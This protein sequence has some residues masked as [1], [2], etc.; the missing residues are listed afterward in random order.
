MNIEDKWKYKASIKD[1]CLEIALWN[2]ILFGQPEDGYVCGCRTEG[3]MTTLIRML[4]GNIKSAQEY[5]R[6]FNY[7][8][9]GPEGAKAVISIKARTKEQADRHYVKIVNLN[10]VLNLDK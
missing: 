6:S 1:D 2:P 4:E 7:N 9:I 3:D 8:L 10:N 5:E